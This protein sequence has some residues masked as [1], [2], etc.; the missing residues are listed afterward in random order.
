MDRVFKIFLLWLLALALPLQ[1]FAVAVK[2]PCEHE[3]LHSRT[4]NPTM[5][6]A[7]RHDAM[8]HGEHHAHPMQ[9]AADHA[10]DDASPACGKHLGTSCCVAAV[11][12]PSLVNWSPAH[13]RLAF[14]LAPPASLFSGHIPEGLKR[15]PRTI[16]V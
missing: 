4:P 16:L 14:A 7:A 12:L 1:G 8:L 13:R 15:P 10:P 6:A 11:M 2:N 3:H 5:Q 9:A